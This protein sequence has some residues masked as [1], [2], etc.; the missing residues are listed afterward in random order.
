[1]ELPAAGV[2]VVRSDDKP[3]MSWLVGQPEPRGRLLV[4]SVG[5]AAQT[6]LLPH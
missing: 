4:A 6:G 3:C 2:V 5:C 1:V